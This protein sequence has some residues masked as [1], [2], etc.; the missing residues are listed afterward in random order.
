MVNLL[1]HTQART[2]TDKRDPPAIASA[3][4]RL[5]VEYT[6]LDAGALCPSM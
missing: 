1:A 6:K 2:M 3:A 4:A 5:A